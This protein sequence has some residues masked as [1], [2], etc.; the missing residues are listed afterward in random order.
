MTGYFIETKAKDDDRDDTDDDLDDGWL[1]N[2]GDEFSGVENFRIEYPLK[3]RTTAEEERQT[4]LMMAMILNGG[5][6]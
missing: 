4:S 2:V 1:I 5:G 3:Q 6:C